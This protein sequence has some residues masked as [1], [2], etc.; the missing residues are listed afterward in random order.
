[1]IH[2]TFDAN[3]DADDSWR[4]VSH[5]YPE[6][7]GVGPTKSAAIDNLN[8]QIIY[9][10]DNNKAEFH[11]RVKERITKGLYCNCGIK[12]EEPARAIYMPERK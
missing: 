8:R 12:L 9:Y 3:Q 10:A 5:N 7:T 11:R 1:M 2:N 4:A 6:F